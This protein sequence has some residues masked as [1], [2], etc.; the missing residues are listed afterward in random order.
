MRLAKLNRSHIT[1]LLDTLPHVVLNRLLRSC[2][3]ETRSVSYRIAQ[4][5]AAV[6]SPRSIA[7]L[8]DVDTVAFRKSGGVLLDVG[9]RR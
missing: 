8:L 3:P 5:P 2:A 7:I 4:D 9:H 1:Q 6:I